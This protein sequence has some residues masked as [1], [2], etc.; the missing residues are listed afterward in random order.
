MAITSDPDFMQAHEQLG[1]ALDLGVNFLDT[2]ESKDPVTTS[3][4][5][6]QNKLT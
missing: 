1:Y 6:V 3:S 4:L 5:K 2:A